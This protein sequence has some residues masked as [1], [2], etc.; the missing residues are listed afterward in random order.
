MAELLIR[1]ESGELAEEIWRRAAEHG[2]SPDEEVRSLVRRALNEESRNPPKRLPTAPKQ[3]YTLIDHLLAMPDAGED[4]MFDRHDPR[5]KR[6]EK[7]P[8]NLED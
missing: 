1:I 6:A 2:V 4:W 7:P 8:I 5:N 3:D